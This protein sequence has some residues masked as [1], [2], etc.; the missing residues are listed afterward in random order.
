MTLNDSWQCGATPAPGVAPAARRRR[1]YVT[2]L[3]S[4]QT[5]T[6]WLTST[7]RLTGRCPC[8]GEGGG[9]ERAGGPDA[10]LDI[11]GAPPWSP[12]AAAL[13]TVCPVQALGAAPCHLAP[14]WASC[15]TPLYSR[16]WAGCPPT[17]LSW[18][19]T[20][21]RSSARTSTITSTHHTP[22]LGQNYSNGNTTSYAVRMCV[23]EF[24]DSNFLPF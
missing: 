4:W 2:G 22:S 12:P 16:T 9:G 14:T 24:E 11:A 17:P 21:T 8:P 7:W 6:E 19:G 5:T 13:C 1:S 20:T 23:G 15:P 3:R 18:W 10:A